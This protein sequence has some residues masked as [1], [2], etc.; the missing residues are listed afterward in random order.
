MLILAFK[1]NLDISEINQY[2]HELNF[3]LIVNRKISW[4]DL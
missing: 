2:F 1:E 3:E 4:N